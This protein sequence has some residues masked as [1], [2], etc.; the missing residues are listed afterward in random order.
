MLLFGFVEEHNS[1]QAQVDSL[2]EKLAQAIQ[3]VSEEREK[4]G[5]LKWQSVAFHEMSGLSCVTDF[6]MTA[7]FG[8]PKSQKVKDAD[9][10][11]EEMKAVNEAGFAKENCYILRYFW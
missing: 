9:D 3:E 7:L 4:A 10:K 6:K 5:Q 11:I 2:E 8:E 1:S